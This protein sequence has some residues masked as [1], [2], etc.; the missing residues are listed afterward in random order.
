MS[1]NPTVGTVSMN[2][3]KLLL[4]GSLFPQNMVIIGLDPSPVDMVAVLKIGSQS[5]AAFRSASAARLAGSNIFSTCNAS[6]ECGWRAVGADLFRTSHLFLTMTGI[7]VGLQ[8]RISTDWMRR[9]LCVLREL[10]SGNT[11][12]N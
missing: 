11:E 5:P 7:S 4:N 6:A 12:H 2:L 9:Q 10:K 3:L 1:Q 8:L